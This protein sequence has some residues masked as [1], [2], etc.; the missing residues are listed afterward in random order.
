MSIFTKAKEAP[1]NYSLELKS[2]FRHMR[3]TRQTLSMLIR[4]LDPDHVHGRVS[5]RFPASVYYESFENITFSRKIESLQAMAND[6]DRLA[7]DLRELVENSNKNISSD[8]QGC[9]SGRND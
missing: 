9:D 1:E 3:G 5:D 2:M 4:K 6:I 7:W 8:S